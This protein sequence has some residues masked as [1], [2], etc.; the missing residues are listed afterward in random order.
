MD[1]AANFRKE[2][3]LQAASQAAQRGRVQYAAAEETI[4]LLFGKWAILRRAK[5]LF[6]A[7]SLAL[8]HRERHSAAIMRRRHGRPSHP[9]STIEERLLSSKPSL[10]AG[11]RGQLV[12][13]A[14]HVRILTMADRTLLPLPLLLPPWPYHL[15]L[16]AAPRF[17]LLCLRLPLLLLLLGATFGPLRIARRP[18]NISPNSGRGVVSGVLVQLLAR[19]VAAKEAP[20][21]NPRL[22]R[23]GSHAE[24]SSPGRSQV[25]W[26]F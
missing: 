24:G 3:E 12:I 9:A 17:L 11:H 21:T 14:N 5:D 23:G 26:R 10:S 4:R 19:P 13:R 18:P 1:S 6:L 15:F 25:M 7:G 8:I 20:P 2:R 16:V 22:A